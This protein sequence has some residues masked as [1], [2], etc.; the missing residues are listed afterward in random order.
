MALDIVIMAA[1]KGTRMKS[2]TH[3]VLHPIAGRPMLMHLMASVDALSPAK[4]MRTPP[5]TSR[6][7]PHSARLRSNGVRAEK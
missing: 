5:T 1:G 3:K 4:K 7:P 2:D 6:N